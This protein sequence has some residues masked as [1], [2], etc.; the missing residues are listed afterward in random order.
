MVY[1]SMAVRADGDDVWETANRCQLTL[2]D[3][4]VWVVV[5]LGIL[6]L[7]FSLLSFRLILS[8]TKY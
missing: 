7:V 4:V 6:C 2:W 3:A 8:P 1:W 5:S